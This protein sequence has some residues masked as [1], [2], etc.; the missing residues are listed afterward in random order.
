[1]EKRRSTRLHWGTGRDLLVD[2][3]NLWWVTQSESTTLN[4]SWPS[5]TCL[6]VNPVDHFRW[7]ELFTRFTFVDSC[8]STWGTRVN[9]PLPNATNSL[10]EH[11][12][13]RWVLMSCLQEKGALVAQHFSFCAHSHHLAARDVINTRKQWKRAF[14]KMII[15]VSRPPTPTECMALIFV[16]FTVR[17]AE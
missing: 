6:L 1:M 13:T 14:W 8:W 17:T 5:P 10:H 16:Q 2:T 9:A 15:Y 12:G 4:E 7:N 11:N 3:G